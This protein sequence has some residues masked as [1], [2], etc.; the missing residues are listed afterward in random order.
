MKICIIGGGTA[1]WLAA[2][3]I[4]K[5]C[6]GQH[7]ITV[8][9]SSKIGIIGAGEGTTG[10]FFNIIQNR[11][12]DFGIN[13]AE[14]MRETGATQKMG[15][16]FTNWHGDGT[17]YIAP[18]DNTIEV[19]E[20]SDPVLIEHCLTQGLDRVHLSTIC[21]NLA[22]HN[23]SSIDRD[24]K[25]TYGY[26]AYHFDGHRVGQYFKR[27][28]LPG[29]HTVIDSE[30][31]SVAVDNGL[32]TSV[33][34]A[35]GE[36]VAADY[37]IDASGFARVLSQPLGTGWHSYRQ[38]L[39]CD[40]AMPF[41]IDHQGPIQPLTESRALSAGW[42]WQIPTQDRIGAGYV[43]DS[44]YITDQEAQAEIEAVLGHSIKPIKWIK[45]DPGR[46][47]QPYT[48]NTMSLG[49]AGSF[50]EP[51]QATSIHTTVAQLQIW[52][53]LMDKHA[54]T[55]AQANTQVNGVVDQF[56]DLVQLHYKSGRSDTVFWQHQQRTATRP[57]VE[58]IR[59]IVN[60]R[61][62]THRD[63][64]QGWGSAGYGVFIYPLIN[65]GW[66]PERHY[67]ATDFYR[68]YGHRWRRHCDSVVDSVISQ[69]QFIDCLAKIPRLTFSKR[70]DSID[71]PVSQ[72]R[73]HPFFKL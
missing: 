46:L 66:I 51:L 27:L 38:H 10:I 69:Q 50:L 31:D 6:P 7:S 63:L 49:L 72:P 47:D 23:L 25:T 14:F 36:S 9:E 4:S 67:T 56:A 64:D 30:V 54:I 3:W 65:Y 15:I 1:G 12:A 39:T 11:W 57:G 68:G 8:I 71:E 58:Y 41:I 20:H 32:V 19:S 16:R 24:L 70:F 40:R 43:Y 73:P 22:E 61:W 13:E 2:L 26:N 55:L 59:N 60:S 5:L 42:M 29:C 35:T 48:K 21:G 53:Q 44:R 34:L 45:F 28:A 62:P 37:W 33:T 17:S 52:H 18:I